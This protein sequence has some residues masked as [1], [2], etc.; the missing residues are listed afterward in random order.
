[1]KNTTRFI[2]VICIGLLALLLQACPP[3]KAKKICKN[4]PQADG[5]VKNQCT[6]NK[7]VP[8]AGV[9][10]KTKL[11]AV[12]SK[13][14]YV[15]FEVNK[16]FP[17]MDKKIVINVEIKTD[18]GYV[19]RDKIT[20]IRSESH[21]S[22]ARIILQPSGNIYAFVP[23]DTQK[24]DTL[25]SKALTRTSRSIMADLDYSYSFKPV[26]GRSARLTDLK[27]QVWEKLP[28]Q[29]L[30]V[31]PTTNIANTPTLRQPVLR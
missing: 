16:E 8:D 21:E 23:Q 30:T 13:G 28:D 3:N 5:T 14:T 25:L 15:L 11:N 29:P 20:A 17:I 12:S 2:F 31:V 24:L 26:R 4:T 22:A 6:T 18:Q 10:N 7:Q 27:L 9:D 1:M 19:V